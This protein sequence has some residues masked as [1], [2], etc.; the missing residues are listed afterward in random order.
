MSENSI[1]KTIKDLNL[2]DSFLFSE[3]TENPE[4]AKLIARIIIKRVFGWQLN[5]IEI[6]S[7]KQYHGY[8][9]GQKATDT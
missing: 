8:R 5:D 1:S 6:E 2:L 7:E 3:L 9:I 4:N